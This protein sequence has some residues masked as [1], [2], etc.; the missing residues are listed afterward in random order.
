MSTRLHNGLALIDPASDLFDVVAAVSAAVTAEFKRARRPIV[1]EEF[2]SLV[3]Q[4]PYGADDNSVFF[5]A[6]SR[7]MKT[8]NEYGTQHALHDP[9]RF[10]IVFG[11]ADSGRV[12]AYPHMTASAEYM[13]ALLS[14]GLF[15]DYHYQNSTDRPDTI[16][17]AEWQQRR[18]D[19]DSVANGDG[20]FSHL[21]A[22]R[23]S[24]LRETFSWELLTEPPFDLDALVTRRDRLTR[25]LRAEL[26]NRRGT[27]EP[28]NIMNVLLADATVARGFVGTLPNDSPH[29]PAP[30][31]P[32]RSRYRDLPGP[33]TV[34]DELVS[35]AEDFRAA[36]DTATK[37]TR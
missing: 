37:P 22:W 9:L 33:L 3:D 16:S 6:D 29:L 21:P 18:S 7:W 30:L 13:D 34:P 11:R 31:P 1:A 32:L 12:L 35:A 8:Q 2:A 10:T 25:A 27:L 36:R 17:A 14:T 5:D 28:S 20:N 24:S 19:W 15:E 26:T 4:G 23:L